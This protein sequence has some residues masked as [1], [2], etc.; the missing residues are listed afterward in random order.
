M[1]IE[2]DCQPSAGEERAN[3]SCLDFECVLLK[4]GRR[5]NECILE[6]DEQRT[7]RWPHCP[8]GSIFVALFG[9]N[10]DRL[11][12]ILPIDKYVFSG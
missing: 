10:F 7:F 4:V 2:D 8:G 5:Y 9:S 12:I 6:T 1:V 11:S 3:L